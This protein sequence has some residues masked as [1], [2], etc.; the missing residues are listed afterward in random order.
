[1]DPGTSALA[2]AIGVRVKQERQSRR[3]TLDQLAEA[4]GVS[5]RML[6]NV[7]QGAANPS[8]GTL[9]RISDAL[10]VGLPTLVEPP[11]PKRVKVIRHGE[12]AALWT[13]RHGGRG[14]LVAG[15]EPPDMLELWD[16]TLQPGDRHASEAHLAGTR[17]L[18]QVQDGTITVEVADQSFTLD[19]G[20]ALT[21]HGDVA[22]AY[23]ND[24]TR[25][26]RFTL[27]VF[28]PGVGSP[29]RS[30]ASDV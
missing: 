5:R 22:H 23:A 4:A 26:A 19:T 14:L 6:I 28:E 13:G 20:D 3:W 7:E 9:L 2:S 18:L 12:G 24:G 11:A 27:A 29:S 1:M 10:G 30:E 25:P 8:V 16:W 21:F 15:T 17:E